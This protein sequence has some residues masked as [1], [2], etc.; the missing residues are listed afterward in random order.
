MDDSKNQS[1][2]ETP[3]EE[4]LNTV[5]EPERDDV[6][7]S[8]AARGDKEA[9]R[10]LVERYQSKVLGLAYEIVRNREDAE[11]ITQETFVKAFLS[12]GSF[13]GQSSFYTWLYRIGY[14]MSVDFKRKL[15][16]RGGVH[17]EFKETLRSS[18]KRSDSESSGERIQDVLTGQSEGPQDALLRKETAAKLRD[19]FKELSDEHRAVMTLREIDGLSYEEIAEITGIPRGTVMSRLHYARKMMQKSLAEYAPPGGIASD[20]DVPMGFVKVVHGEG[21]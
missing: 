19:V 10:V 17:V 14:N 20:V 8:R 18:G 9:Y 13:K 1:A 16:R 6:L 11:D 2:D 12:L 21:K 7:V 3:A 15:N 5:V 4:T